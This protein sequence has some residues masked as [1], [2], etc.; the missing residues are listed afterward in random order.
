MKIKF[1]TRT[2]P[3]GNAIDA[4]SRAVGRAMAAMPARVGWRPWFRLRS[5]ALSDKNLLLEYE[6]Y[7][8]RDQAKREPTKQNNKTPRRRP[9]AK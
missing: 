4:A 1:S 2:R 8:E 6:V 9:K 7:Y 5:F 3:L